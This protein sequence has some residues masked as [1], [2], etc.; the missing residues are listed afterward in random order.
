MKTKTKE[1]THLFWS[2]VVLTS[3]ISAVIISKTASID[4]YELLKTYIIVILLIGA[5]EAI[6]ITSQLQIFNDKSIVKDLCIGYILSSAFLCITT[7][8]HVYFIWILGSIYIA[9]K[10]HPYVGIFFQLIF[11]FIY[12]SMNSYGIQDFIYNFMIGC[13]LCI[14]IR[15]ADTL[16]A[17]FYVLLIVGSIQIILN[18]LMNNFVFQQSISTNSLYML[19]S[20]FVLVIVGYFIRPNKVVNEKDI[21]SELESKEILVKAYEKSESSINASVQPNEIEEK[22]E[23]KIEENY[24]RFIT[25]DAPLMKRLNDEKPNTYRHSL[26]IGILSEKAAKKIG[27]NETLAKAGGFYHEIGK[28]EKGDYIEEGVQLA[29]LQ[30]L[31]TPLVN[32]IK[33][34]N[35]K[36]EKPD[37]KESA[38]VLL[39][40]SIITTIKYFEKQPNE[41]RRSND[42]IIDNIFKVRL[43]QGILE[44]VP[45]TLNEFHTLKEFYLTNLPK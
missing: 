43:E 28:L 17:L 44:K 42:K 8:F 45:L 13:I 1:Y 32:I 10:V 2:A 12:C 14:L 11:T 23:D 35:G 20:G 25:S 16:I 5:F 21:F 31:P 26:L 34:Q 15:F 19:L 39:S 3:L 9:K 40:D 30:E 37:S 4:T 29:M 33:Q 27:A 18:F 24:A 38:I 7:T 22:T 6:S 36:I 41:L